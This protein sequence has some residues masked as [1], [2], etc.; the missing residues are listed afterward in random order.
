MKSM[1]RVDSCW[2]CIWSSSIMADS[3]CHV[4]YIKAKCTGNCV[5]GKCSRISKILFRSLG[6]NFSSNLFDLRQFKTLTIFETSSWR[7]KSV[8]IRVTHK[9]HEHL[10]HTNNDDSIVFFIHQQIDAN[11]SA[12]ITKQQIVIDVIYQT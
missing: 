11:L 3:V 6:Q 12:N 5:Q 1:N 4:H 9:I 2:L 8:S 10:P 7:C